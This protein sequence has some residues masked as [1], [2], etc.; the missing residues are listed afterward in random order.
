MLQS[1]S[2]SRYGDF[3]YFEVVLGAAVLQATT[4][5]PSEMGRGRVGDSLKTV[6]AAEDTPVSEETELAG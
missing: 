1:S 4:P 6:T 3:D 2:L 5:P